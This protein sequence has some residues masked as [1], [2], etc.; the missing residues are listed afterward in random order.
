MNTKK[1]MYVLTVASFGMLLGGSVHAGTVIADPA[2]T[3]T[4]PSVPGGPGSV[5]PDFNGTY[6]KLLGADASGRP[7][8]GISD[9]KATGAYSQDAASPSNNNES[10]MLHSLSLDPY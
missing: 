4:N 8:T 2:D 7:M 3:M 10:K 1:W 9:A 5:A 6:T